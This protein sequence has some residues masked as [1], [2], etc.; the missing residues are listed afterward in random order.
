MKQKRALTV[1]DISCVGKCSLTV[2]LPVL[3]AAGVETS[4]LPTSILSTHTGGFGKPYFRDLTKDIPPVVTHWKSFGMDFDAIGTG[5][6]GSKEQVELMLS[7]FDDFGGAFKVVDP[8]MADHGKLYSGFSED[9]PAEMA[10]LC[11]K[12]DLILP[13]FTEAAL[14]LGEPF[15]EGPYTKEYAEGILMRLAERFP[16]SVVLTGVHFDENML[17]SA[18]FDRK[19]GEIS[20]TFAPRIP[21]H[22][23]GTGDLFAASLLAALLAGKT[24]GEASQISADFIVRSIS[25]SDPEREEKYGVR[26]E[27]ALPGLMKDLGLV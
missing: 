22:Y 20:F 15:K 18:A 27:A 7:L 19:R 14:L 26:F 9:F 6:L 5:Y 23:H 10:K 21:G 17:G 2:V 13:N 3:S 16:G 8:V 4:V 1:Q 24:L 12:A 11:E 25:L